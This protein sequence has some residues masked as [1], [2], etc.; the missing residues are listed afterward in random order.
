MK[1]FVTGGAG[2]IGSHLVDELIKKNNK[3]VVYDNLSLGSKEFIK[4]HFKNKN[5]KFIKGDLLDQKLLNKSIKGNDFVFHLAAN[6]DIKKS[7]LSPKIDFEQ[8]V[9]ATF[10]VIEAMRLN[11]INKVA[12]SSFF[13][14]FGEP[15]TMPTP[16]NYGP[17]KPVSVYGAAKLSCEA[18]ISSYSHVFNWNVWVFRFANVIGPRLT[19]GAIFDF[20][21]KLK[22]DQNILQV[23][24]NGKQKKSYIYVK[25]C[26]DGII[27]GIKNGK[28]KFNIL[29]LGTDDSI[30]VAGIAKV[31][32]QELE[33]HKT[34]ILFTGGDR[35]WVGDVPK[36]L[37]DTRLMKSL[38][39]TPKLNSREAVIQTIKAS[40]NKK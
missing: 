14:I 15:K 28:E 8:G 17:L 32:L 10:N 3:V 27:Y 22:K 20:I 24:G 12:F 37:L 18:L 7:S 40:I 9:L 11:K 13:A 23:L 6:S 34:K 4:D 38:G 29:N 2:F 25:D 26:V 16:E 5:F 36:M 39:W 31:L 1:Y 21:N 30:E 19:H 35:G 33:L